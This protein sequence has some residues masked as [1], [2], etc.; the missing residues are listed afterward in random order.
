MIKAIGIYREFELQ[1]RPE[2]DRRILDLTAEKLRKKG[3][4]VLLKEP[5]DFSGQECPDLIF[6]MARGKKINEILAEKEKGGLFVINPPQGI[7][8]S[9]NRELAYQKM[10]EFGVNIPETRAAE[11]KNIK[12]S[13]IQNRSILKAAVRHEFCFAKVKFLLT[14]CIGSLSAGI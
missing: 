8:I 11:I 3:F 4:D 10:K 2:K 7:R 9:F 6:T 12:F 5:K 14:R 13:D 1:G